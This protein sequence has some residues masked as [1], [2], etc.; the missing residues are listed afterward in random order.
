M[1][2]FQ[3]NNATDFLFEK[4]EFYPGG[5]RNG[6]VVDDGVYANLDEI[7]QNFGKDVV[8]ERQTSDC[9]HFN[10]PVDAEEPFYE[11]ADFVRCTR[12]R[13]SDNTFSRRAATQFKHTV[14][15]I[16]VHY[17]YTYIHTK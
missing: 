7:K 8:G 9:G 16:Y 11:T 3:V 14:S 5:D 6:V 13:M 15:L 1:R 2:Q 10:R 17:A 12:D 4:N